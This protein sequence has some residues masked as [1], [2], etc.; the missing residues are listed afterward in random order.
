MKKI[1]LSATVALT[2]A[3]FGTAETAHAQMGPYNPPIDPS[4]NIIR[5]GSMPAVNYFN[6]VQP[7]QQ[8]NSAIG[9]L[10][11]QQ[12][13]MGQGMGQNTLGST[14]GHPVMFGSY[15]QYYNP[16]GALALYGGGGMG[17]G[18]MGMGGMGMG[19]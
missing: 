4:I 16:R 15:L 1:G 11:S 8:F 6:L 13:A 2:L 10:E 19:R 14:T 18:G 17:M 9:S 5:G 3:V 7:L 12:N